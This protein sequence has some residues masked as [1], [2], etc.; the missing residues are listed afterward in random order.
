[1]V[2][3]PT[4][5]ASTATMP[6]AP[7]GSAP[8]STSTLADSRSNVTAT[9][10]A[11]AVPL[12]QG[13]LIPVEGVRVDQLANTFDDARAAGRSHDAIDIMAPKGTRVLAATDG[14]VVK[15]FTSVRG[16]LTV[17]QF[18]PTGTFSYYYAHL[19]SYAP[20]LTEGT[21]LRRGDLVGFVGSSGD[22][23]PVAPHLHFAIN[24]LGAEKN[25]WQGTA[26][27]PYPILT[28]RH[29]N[30]PRPGGTVPDPNRH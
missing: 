23:N 18:D 13:L 12:P 29:S 2:A 10:D 9:P 16:G 21:H 25:W 26:I 11:S 4:A 14:K 1:M 24:V 28:G 20:G 19:D 30:A 7:T 5:G 8:A 6:S 15:L 22:A 27:N 3:T 17:Y